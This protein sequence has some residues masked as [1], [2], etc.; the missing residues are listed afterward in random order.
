MTG[1][2]ILGE[3]FSAVYILFTSCLDWAERIG[4]LPSRA[5]E[6]SMGVLDA[7]ARRVRGRKA[8]AEA[9]EMTSR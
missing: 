6:A 9:V 8:Y 7:Y 1:A 5:D 4:W 2:Y 3:E